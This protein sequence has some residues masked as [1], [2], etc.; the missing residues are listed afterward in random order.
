MVL[1]HE[2]T[3]S[4]DPA[5]RCRWGHRHDGSDLGGRGT[6]RCWL[7][8]APRRRGAGAQC[9]RRC[10]GTAMLLRHERTRSC[11]PAIRCRWG[12][13]RGG[14]D[15][16]GRRTLRCGLAAAP[17]RRE[18]G[19]QCSRRCRGTAMLLR[20]ECTRSCDPAIRCRW[21]HRRGGSDR[22]GR[23]TLRCGLAAAPRRREIGA[24]YRVG[25]RRS[26][27]S[28]PVPA[29]AGQI[30]AP[31]KAKKHTKNTHKIKIKSK[32][33][34]RHCSPRRRTSS[35]VLRRLRSAPSTWLWC[36]IHPKQRKRNQA[37]SI[38]IETAKN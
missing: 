25:S 29:A 7:A 38:Y 8:A 23:R 27:A 31:E 24:Q 34:V 10:R 33:I 26:L 12:H 22:G 32:L 14:S 9:S 15:R 2:R 4:C 37:A 36:P 18:T 3:R 21:G 35:K 30:L 13:R 16:G 17:R 19:A 28:S 1:R 6:L 20:H 11:D 5:I